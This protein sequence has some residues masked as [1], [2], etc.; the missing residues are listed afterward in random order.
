ME[1][2]M[3]FLAICIFMTFQAYAGDFDRYF[4]PSTLRVDYFHTGTKTDEVFTIDELFQ[5]GEWAGSRTQLVDTL[6]LGEYYVRVYDMAST[7]IIYSR[8]FSTIFNEWQSTDEAHRGNRK[9]FSESVRIP[10]PRRPIQL[11]IARRDKRMMFN[12]IFSTVIDP[13]D[14]TM[15]KK[16]NRS[17]GYVTTPLM[18][19]GPSAN[20]VDIVILGDGYTKSEKFRADAKRMNDALFQTEPFKSRKKDFN[21][22]LVEVISPDSGVDLPDKNVWKDSPLGVEYNVFG[23][24]RYAL[25]LNNKALRDAAGAAPYD[26]ICILVNETRYGG[27]GIYNLYATTYT[28]EQTAS[29]QWQMEYVYVHEFGHSFAGLGDEYYS[30]S[31]GYTDFY[32]P[33]VEPWEPNVTATRDATQLK[34]AHHMKQ[35]TA[36]PTPWEKAAYD[37]I[38]ALQRKLDRLA[39]DY[40]EKRA[41]LH[42]A[43]QDIMSTSAYA[44]IVGLFEG[45]GYASTGLFRPALDCRMFSLSLTTF[46]PVCSA[47]IVR[48]IESY[49]R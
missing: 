29:Q 36:I 39:P 46:D 6:N 37:S 31:T 48:V 20:R 2:S 28:N 32:A 16:E 30:S 19:N 35:G 8:G 33:G 11:S 25:T 3:R 41:P 40:Y 1:A 22:W 42:K 24:A 15:I 10:F 47:A 49:T 26:A 13:N 21:V 45:A 34:W 43:L 18:R 12:E 38:T 14:P 4:I 7:A 23:S 44:G 9:T 27:G 5:E 17:R